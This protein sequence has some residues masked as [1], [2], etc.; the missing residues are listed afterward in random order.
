MIPYSRQN[1]DAG[2]IQSVV[3]VL[4]SD[5][6]TQGPL[7]P[8]F[9]R[10]LARYCGAKYAVAVSNGT[11]AL[12]LAYLAAG[13]KRG[14][15]VITTPNTFAATS[16]MALAVGAKPGFCDIRPVTWNIDE[17]KIERLITVKTKAVVPGG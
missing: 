11:A 4:R 8:E 10:A 5:F 15:E 2:D 1:I 16:N 7:V 13:L 14:D 17:S 9:E 12:R 6:I 3:D